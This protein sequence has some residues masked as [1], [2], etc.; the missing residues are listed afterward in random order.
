MDTR[1]THRSGSEQQQIRWR[2]SWRSTHLR[3]PLHRESH[4]SCAGLYSD[5]LY[6]PFFCAHTS[7]PRYARS[8]PRANRIARLPDLSADEYA[9]R[10]ASEPF[11]LTDPVRRWPAFGRWTTDAIATCA[12]DKPYA[13]TEAKS[14]GLM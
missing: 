9:A 7:L 4:V 11:I 3:L 5:W 2:G 1:L 13:Y 12:R 8:I 14:A 6:R 10:W